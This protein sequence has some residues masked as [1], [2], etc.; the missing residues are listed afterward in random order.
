M[1]LVDH[2]N[3]EGLEVP[4]LV[5][6]RLYPRNYHRLFCIA[7]VKPCRI[8][9]HLQLWADGLYLTSI[10]FNE[11]L[12]MRQYKNASTPLL[13]NILG[14]LRYAERLTACRRNHY[15]WIV[16]FLSKMI[17]HRIDCVSLVRS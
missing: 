12:N 5:I 8:H 13:N 15:T 11:L 4:E 17:V 3:I 16:V 2:H 6:D 7:P 10:L 1:N 14:N 9:T